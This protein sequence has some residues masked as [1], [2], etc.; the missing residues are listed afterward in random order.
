MTKK[1]KEARENVLNLLKI[2]LRNRTQKTYSDY[3]RATIDFK[4]RFKKRFDPY[5]L[6][7]DYIDSYEAVK[8]YQIDILLKDEVQ[9]SQDAEQH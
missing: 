5:N 9:G 1:C 4:Y 6:K 2:Y 3:V 7:D 8:M